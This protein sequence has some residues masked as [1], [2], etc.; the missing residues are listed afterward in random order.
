M[1]RVKWSHL[2]PTF[3]LFHRFIFFYT[4]SRAGGCTVKKRAISNHFFFQHFFPPSPTCVTSGLE[5]HIWIGIVLISAKIVQV[6]LVG[7]SFRCWIRCNLL[8]DWFDCYA[9]V[10]HGRFSVCFLTAYCD[11]AIF[12]LWILRQLFVIFVD[13][14]LPLFMLIGWYA[15]L[16]E[17]EWNASRCIDTY[18]TNTV[19]TVIHFHL[20]DSNYCLNHRKLLRERLIRIN[21]VTSAVTSHYAATLLI[22]ENQ[23]SIFHSMSRSETPNVCFQHAIIET[24]FVIGGERGGV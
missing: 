14:I 16:R 12:F 15:T 10:F 7:F 5:K 11:M 4:L 3:H 9:L 22:S 13:W 8:R 6:L 2:C 20:S 19:R 23:R 17:K 24:L 1:G 21:E 18:T